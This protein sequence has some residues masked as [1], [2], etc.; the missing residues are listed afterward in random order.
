MK[1]YIDKQIIVRKEDFGD[2]FPFEAWEENIAPM[3]HF[4][5]DYCIWNEVTEDKII[6]REQKISLEEKEMAEVLWHFKE[7]LELTLDF[8]VESDRIVCTISN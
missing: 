5:D 3:K 6:L 2:G 8:H 4:H 1:A 7:M